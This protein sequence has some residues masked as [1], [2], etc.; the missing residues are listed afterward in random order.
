M[1]FE[2]P[3]ALL[4]DRR[5]VIAVG[6][7]YAGGTMARLGITT[8]DLADDRY[9]SV[10]SYTATGDISERVGLGEDPAAAAIADG[11]AADHP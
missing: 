1:N 9:V 10:G 5:V 8:S 3:A 7:G 11:G 4:K 2:K 6:V